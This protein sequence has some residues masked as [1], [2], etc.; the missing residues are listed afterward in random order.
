MHH[1]HHHHHNQLPLQHTT[2]GSV[3]VVV[4]V[5]VALASA[6]DEK[7]EGLCTMTQRLQYVCVVS[8]NVGIITISTLSILLL[9]TGCCTSTSPSPCSSSTDSSTCSVGRRR[10]IPR[11]TP[12]III[13]HKT[14]Y[15]SF[16]H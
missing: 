16:S 3:V 8:W 15:V 2:M 12:V 7:D 6:E 1:H 14:T 13:H 10:W 5:V 11:F 9:S 4:V